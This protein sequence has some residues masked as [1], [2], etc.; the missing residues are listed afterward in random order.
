MLVAQF[1]SLCI[2]AK[3]I[4]LEQV[5]PG[6]M[7]VGFASCAIQHNDRTGYKVADKYV[8]A[9]MRHAGISVLPYIIPSMELIDADAMS[10][11]LD[12][13]VLP[14][15]LSNVHPSRYDTTWAINE[16]Q[17]FD[18]RRDELVW[19]LV[20][21]MADQ[22]KPIL[23]ICRGMQELNVIWGGTLDPA[24]HE[25][26]DRIDHR[27]EYGTQ[28]QRYDHNHMIHVTTNGLLE[29]LWRPIS[30]T[31]TDNQPLCVAVNSL[32]WQGV[33]CLGKGLEIEAVATDGQIEAFRAINT[34]G[35]VLGVQWH[36][37]ANPDDDPYASVLFSA[38]ARAMK[39]RVKSGML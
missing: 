28:D 1:V 24:L 4:S 7:K 8:R 38:F 35:F 36:P 20:T 26:E 3:G 12:G 27:F 17:G 10:R 37:E 16:E 34:S 21:A 30:P 33:K 2:P 6:M 14:G 22:G 32:H 15:S 18:I 5:V 23:G 13:L 29:Q 11:G 31:L 19:R 9:M 25:R 39:V